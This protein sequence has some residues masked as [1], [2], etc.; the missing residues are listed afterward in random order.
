MGKESLYHVP[1]AILS[2]HKVGI[3]DQN[4][5]V[6]LPLKPSTIEPCLK[7]FLK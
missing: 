2:L 5:I 4:L 6:N 1:T 7:L 3:R